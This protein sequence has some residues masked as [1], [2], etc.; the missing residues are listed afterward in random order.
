MRNFILLSA[1]LLG[2]TTAAAQNTPTEPLREISVSSQAKTFIEADTLRVTVLIEETGAT[3]EK[4][5][6]A[7][8]AKTK[9]VKEALGKLDPT[10]SL[11]TRGE[12]FG[13]AGSKLVSISRN[14]AKHAQ[15][16]LAA[17]T[18]ATTKA[19]AIIDAAIA[20]GA[21]EVTDVEYF[22][23]EESAAHLSAVK[24]ATARGRKKAEL[25]ADSL[26]VSLGELLSASITEQPSGAVQRYNNKIGRDVTRYSEKELNI[27]ANLRFAVK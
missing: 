6:A 8:Q 4:A 20:A 23:R 11:S 10:L 19:S 1:V 14:S 18:S 24:E 13:S 5:Y 12:H 27:H 25:L 15:L 2:A 3:A 9:L 17:R 7:L 26:G 21:K 16:F 22:V